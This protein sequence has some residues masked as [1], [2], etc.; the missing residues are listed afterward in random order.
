MKN[1]KKIGHDIT[2]NNFVVHQVTKMAGDKK[3]GLKLA[4]STLRTT[5]KESAFIAKITDAYSKKS[6]PTY[7]IFNTE[8]KSNEFQTSLR[9]FC[10][11]K[12]DFISFTKRSMNYYKTI[13]EKKC[14]CKWWF[15]CICLL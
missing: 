1:I 13:I 2:L 15:C 6:H 12:T 5:I 7:G 10:A 9:E 8:S 11:G 4:K 3:T 14:T